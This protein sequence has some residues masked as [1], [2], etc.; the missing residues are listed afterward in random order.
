MTTR[1]QLI[2][3]L[4]Q[5]PDEVVQAVFDFLHRIQKTQQTHPLA[6]FAG[7]LSDAEAL[8]LQQSIQ[9]NCRRVE[10]DEW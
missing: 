4:Q 5:V 2:L 10:I 6:G 8:E 1:E 9:E 7:I 3:E